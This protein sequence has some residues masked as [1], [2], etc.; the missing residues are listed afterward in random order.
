MTAPMAWTD[1]R[2][3][4][5]R[6][7]WAEGLSA[8]QCAARLGGVTRNAVIG[9]IS[10]LGLS[11]RSA[12]TRTKSSRKQARTR[13]SAAATHQMR[14]SRS[15]GPKASPESFLPPSETDIPR[16]RFAD[17]NMTTQCGWI[18]GEAKPAMCCGAASVPGQSYCEDHVRRASAA[19]AARR[20]FVPGHV[21]RGGT[22]NQ[23]ERTGG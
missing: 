11:S 14:G 6:K 12:I 9:K 1:E 15:Y 10:R 16:L 17:R 23:L 2:T 3:G 5:V 20:V 18:C 8:S 21:H 22:L 13:A 7:L 4:M 19:P